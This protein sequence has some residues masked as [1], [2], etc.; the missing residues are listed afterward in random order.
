LASKTRLSQLKKGLA[1]EDKAMDDEADFFDFTKPIFQ[2]PLEEHEE[3]WTG[4][5]IGGIPQTD[6]LSLAR[7]YRMAADAIV[8]EALRSSDYSYE[9]AYPALVLVPSRHRTLS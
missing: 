8:A 5:V 6:E 4:F 7:S 9:F 2:E 3:D 1:T